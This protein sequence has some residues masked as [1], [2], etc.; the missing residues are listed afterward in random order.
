MKLNDQIQC[1]LDRARQ[2][3]DEMSKGGR[4]ERRLREIDLSRDQA[5]ALGRAQSRENVRTLVWIRDHPLT[6]MR[7]KL[8]AI[9]ILE[10]RWGFPKNQVLAQVEDLQPK[11]IEIRQFAPPPGWNGGDGGAE[12]PREEALLS[13]SDNG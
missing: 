10:D 13:A 11:L 2:A 12:P 5:R 8:E 6:S 1:K 9:N 3:R 7:D 4:R